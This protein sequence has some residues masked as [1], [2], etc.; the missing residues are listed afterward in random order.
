MVDWSTVGSSTSWRF[1]ESP[2]MPRPI[3]PVTPPK[4]PPE[5]APVEPPE[6]PDPTPPETPWATPPCGGYCQKWGAALSGKPHTAKIMARAIQHE[7]AVKEA[8]SLVRD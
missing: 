5:G 3:P 8:T 4:G 6:G 2:L 7:L 1:A